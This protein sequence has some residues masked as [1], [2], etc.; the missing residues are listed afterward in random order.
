MGIVLQFF[1]NGEFS[2]G[3]DTSKRRRDKLRKDAF[4]QTFPLDPKRRD[5]YLQWREDNAEMLSEFENPSPG[6]TYTSLCNHTYTLVS[7]GKSESVLSWHDN[8][9]HKYTTRV[10]SPFVAVAFRWRLR[11]L[12]HQLV[13]SCENPESIDIA[14]SRKKLESMTKNMARNIRNGV[15]LLEQEKGG[16]DCLSFLTLTLP[17]LSKEGLARC[18]ENWDYMVKRFIDFLRTRIESKNIPFLYVYATE[19]Q[20][21]RLENR[22]EYAPHLH[23]VF[24]GRDG[25][26]K[27]WVITPK[28]ARKAWSACIAAVVDELFDRSA[29]ENLQRIKY[30]AARYLSKYLS[31]GKC[32]IPRD[33]LSPVAGSLRTQWGGM[34]R[35]VSRSI[36]LHRVRIASDQGNHVVVDA[37]L[38][39]LPKLFE[40]KLVRYY[41]FGFIPLHKSDA[42]GAEYGLHVCGGCLSTPT[43]ENGLAPVFDYLNEFIQRQEY[44][45]FY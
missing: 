41:R 21:K 45:T 13:E 17:A 7:C 18:C 14:S 32:A 10:L 36:S 16:K 30:S 19:I 42:D 12:V 11:P 44:L 34:A 5:E 6:T 9:G 23:L 29:L 38:K 26:K 40:S 37:F 1:P 20:T 3:V 27:P 28:Q 2:Q 33:G 39:S 24:R 4:T 31:K 8:K 43:F 25:R 35:A 15:Y 22:N